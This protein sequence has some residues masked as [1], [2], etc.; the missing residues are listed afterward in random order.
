LFI[1]FCYVVYGNKT[2]S[3]EDDNNGKGKGKFE[4]KLVSEYE[5][6]EQ[7]WQGMM[8]SSIDELFSY[9]R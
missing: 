5:N 2:V 9:Y 4:W 6:I 7:P 8:F 3:D 1:Y